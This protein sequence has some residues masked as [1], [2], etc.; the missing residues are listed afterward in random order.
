MFFTA[1]WCGPC[2]QFAPIVCEV[3]RELQ[4]PVTVIN[5]DESGELADKAQIT[6]L[7]SCVLVSDGRYGP[8]I[9]GALP[10]I[11]FRQ[12]LVDQYADLSLC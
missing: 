5:V 3:A 1:S 10:K 4:I 8:P 2:Q 6:D 7:P 11:E 12:Y 9:V